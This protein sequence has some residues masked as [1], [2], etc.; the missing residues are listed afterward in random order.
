MLLLE[1]ITTVFLRTCF[2]ISNKPTAPCL[3]AYVPTCAYPQAYAC[4]HSMERHPLCHSNTMQQ[5]RVRNTSG[6]TTTSVGAAAHTALGTPAGATGR[7]WL[8]TVAR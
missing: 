8:H 7:C 2:H 5:R 6:Y 1:S 3:H 4:G